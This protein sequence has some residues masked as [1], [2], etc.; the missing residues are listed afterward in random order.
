MK[1]VRLHCFGGP[2]VLTI[3]DVE[4][5]EPDPTEVLV[6]VHAAGVNPVDAKT[7][8]GRGVSGLLGNPPFTLGW[9]ASGVVVRCGPGV[10]RFREGDLVHGLVGFPRLGSAYAELL[11]AP[12][13]HLAPMPPGLSHREAAALPL[14]GLTAWQALIDTA[15]ITAGERVLIHA[16]SGGVGHLAVQIARYADAEVLGTASSTKHDL[17]REL[18]AD[19]VIDHRTTDFA[20]LGPVDVVLD[21]VGGDTTARS[22]DLLGPGG[23]LVSLLSIDSALLDRARAAGIDAR[24]M[25]VE[26]DHAGMAGIDGLVQQGHLRCV[27]DTALPLDAV[28]D[29]HRRI[30]RGGGVGKV[31][32]DVV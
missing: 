15:G 13:R 22:L 26:P 17:I 4:D 7:R 23:T 14:A 30:E 19:R 10:T 16:A 24:F 25:L 27:V 1:A 3:E 5:P 2:E 6:R 11:V 28:A 8:A 31:V 32:L 18:G 20:T 9:D 21:P 29:A 12:S